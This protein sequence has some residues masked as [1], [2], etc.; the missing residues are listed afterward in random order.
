MPAVTSAKYTSSPRTISS[1]PNTPRPPSA[2]TIRAAIDLR[3]PARRAHVL[4]LPG[5]QHITMSSPWPIGAQKSSVGPAGPGAHREQGDAEVDLDHRLGQHPAV[6]RPVTGGTAR[7]Q[8]DSRSSRPQDHRLPFAGR[9]RPPA[10]PAAG[11]PAWCGHRLQLV[12]RSG[13]PERRGRQAELVGGQPAQSLPVGGE[14]GAARRWAP[15]RRIPASAAAIKASAARPTSVAVTTK[16]GCS[17]RSPPPARR[18]RSSLTTS[19]WSA[20]PCAGASAYALDRDHLRAKAVKGDRQLAA[21]L[22]GP[23]QHLDPV[24]GLGSIA[25]SRAATV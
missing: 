15:P 24:G 5:L 19:D 11:K 18:R 8:A 1:T 23:Q 25:V 6:G 7:C 12:D 22:P 9:P 3:A 20:T 13:E 21:E 16:S 2:L 17:R 14:P 4:R 10:S